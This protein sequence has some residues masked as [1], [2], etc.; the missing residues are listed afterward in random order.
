MNIKQF[1]Y[2]ADNLGYLVY[3]DKTAIAVDG[4]AAD[5]IISFVQNRNLELKYVTNTHSH[6]DHTI[7]RCS[8]LDVGCSSLFCPV[9]LDSQK[10]RAVVD[11]H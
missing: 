1:R 6:M 2:A 4:G 7:I 10:A 8:K 3:G 5:K 9:H 11:I